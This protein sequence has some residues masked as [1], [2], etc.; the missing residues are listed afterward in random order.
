[1]YPHKYAAQHPQRAAFIMAGSGQSVSYAEFEMRANRLAHLL[2]AEGLDHRI[3]QPPRE[4]QPM[5][6]HHHGLGPRVAMALVSGAAQRHLCGWLNL[7][8]RR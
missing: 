1:M 6:Q 8:H 2:R 4:P 5:D 7:H 3:K